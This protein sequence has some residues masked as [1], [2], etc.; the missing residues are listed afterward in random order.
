MNLRY[1]VRPLTIQQLLD[2]PFS[3]P[4]NNEIVLRYGYYHGFDVIMGSARH[5]HLVFV[6]AEN[7]LS[8]RPPLV[9]R[10]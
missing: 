1:G 9:R 10:I 4:N 6:I 7:L 5:P 8:I 3:L 2:K